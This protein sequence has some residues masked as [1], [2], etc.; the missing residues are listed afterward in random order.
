M[1]L[2]NIFFIALFIFSAALQYNDPDPF[3]WIC[4][5]LYGATLC[6]L[7]IKKRYNPLL[8]ILGLTI[9]LAYAIYLFVDSEGVQSWWLDHNA[10]N[11]VQTMKA[12]K[13]WIEETREF[14]GLMIL[15]IVL[16]INMVWL[17]RER[18]AKV[19]S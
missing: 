9:Y 13:P 19:N 18:K 15:L 7:A 5:Y 6:Y 16:I 10:E 3:V 8:Y 17:S 1:K 11:I 14:F 2:F 12:E 4:I